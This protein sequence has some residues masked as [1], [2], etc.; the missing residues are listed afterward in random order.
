MRTSRK[1]SDDTSMRATIIATDPNTGQPELDGSLTMSFVSDATMGS[2]APSGMFGGRATGDYG[3]FTFQRSMSGE[4]ITW[5]YSLASEDEPTFRD[6]YNNLVALTSTSTG[7]T[8]TVTLSV[9]DMGIDGM[10]GTADDLK[11]SIVLTANIEGVDDRK[12]REVDGT[13]ATTVAEGEGNTASDDFRFFINGVQ[14]TPTSW[15]GTL[16]EETTNVE[17]TGTYGTLQIARTG[18]FS[19]TPFVSARLDALD[20]TSE[21]G[22]I[23][24]DP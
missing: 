8:D 9:Y 10:A 11:G 13:T 14:E 16:V 23:A 21:A 20:A 7:I 2:I 12:I 22:T 1:G 19:Y 18:L 17:Y 3:S 4:T 15:G 5:T 6:Q 24:T